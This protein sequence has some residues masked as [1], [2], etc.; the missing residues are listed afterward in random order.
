MKKGI[1]NRMRWIRYIEASNSQILSNTLNWHH[2]YY[3]FASDKEIRGFL[4]YA[5]GLILCSIEEERDVNGLFK[6]LLRFKYFV[7]S[8]PFAFDETNYSKD[9]Y[10]FQHG[11]IG[12]L[13]SIF[14]VYFQARFFLIAQRSGDL[15]EHRLSRRNQYTLNF[16]KLDDVLHAQLLKKS[17][18]SWD[19]VSVFLDQLRDIDSVDH[20]RIINAFFWY[21]EA[22]R[23]LGNNVE[24]FFVKM[25]SCIESLAQNKQFIYKDDLNKKLE[26][27]QQ[28][29][30][31]THEEKSEI[32]NWL[33]NR[34]IQ[35]K[36]VQFIQKYSHGFFKGGN[37]KPKECFI[38]KGDAE[39]NL[40]NI[41][42]A[43]SKYLHSGDTMY[44]CD[45]YMGYRD[46][47]VFPGSGL[48]VD[49]KK[50]FKREQI[51]RSKWFESIVNY[52]LK[53]FINSFKK[54]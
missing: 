16:K 24:L 21:A 11:M 4:N 38:K 34:K 45:D 35:Y 33:N 25:V 3:E 42:S 19:T 41:Y 18:Y 17:D 7:P 29:F 6:Y 12:E 37:R 8:E 54:S 49:Q 2:E 22:V 31:L 23:E 5:N 50:F 53:S 43:R 15:T 48:M 44:H 14:S 40:I 51:P 30:E 52:S 10:Y 27:F 47:D 26:Q 13:L 20:Q 9:G 36:F 32:N 39:R 28:S 1:V 46:W